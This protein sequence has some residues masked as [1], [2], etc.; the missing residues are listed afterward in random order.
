[1]IKLS[2]CMI[3]KDEEEV[4]ARC[5]ESVSAYVDE[6]VIADTGSTDKTKKIARSY[7]ARVFGFAW[8]ED[9]A[10]ARNFA[11]SKAEGDYLMWLDADDYISPENGN[12]LAALKERLALEPADMVMCP[13]DVAFDEQGAPTCTFFRERIVKRDVGY[14][15]EGRVHECIAPRGKV[16]RSD[17]RVFHL[18]SEKERG[19][20]NL[21]IYQRWAKEETLSPRDLFY[22]GREL[23]YNRLYTEAIA[24][25]EEM[26]CG[27][28]WYVNKIEA[29]KILSFCHAEQKKTDAALQDLFR[30]FLYG[31]PRASVL[32]AIADLYKAQKRYPE[33]AFFYQSALSCR[34]HSDEGDFEEPRC[35]DLIPLL[36]LVCTYYAAGDKTRALQAHKK[37][38]ETFPSHPSVRFN[39]EFFKKAGLS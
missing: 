27:K 12:R 5:L 6:I 21:H 39:R 26:L 3:V 19:P 22:Y 28:G 23:Y 13:Y 29:C 38:E 4:L 35:R 20:R 25:L 34:D 8:R 33:A 15:W 1:M 37:T 36:G 32:C 11:F 18:G 9:F 31:E 10:A 16:I 17:F 30:S 24:V 7:G 2:L 14:L